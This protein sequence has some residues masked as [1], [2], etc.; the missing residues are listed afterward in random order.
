VEKDVMNKKFTFYIVLGTML[1]SLAQV[2]VAAPVQWTLA[3]GGNGHWYDEI[4]F[5]ETWTSSNADAQNQIF[6]GMLGHLATITSAEENA[7]I[8]ANLSANK[9]W[10]GGFKTGADWNWVTGE[11]FTFTNWA[12]VE[13]NNLGGYENFLQFTP[14]N[15]LGNWNDNDNNGYLSGID[16]GY[17]VEFAP[18]PLP[19]AAWLF[20]S[21]LGLLGWMRR[22][23][24]V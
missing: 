18:V 12:P 20:G 5:C 14:D 8:W 21:A 24:S 1:F 11:D 13:P 10:L 3:S 17:V 6:N 2:S 22:K 7:F 23:Q 15:M 4:D 19:A 16:V 9:R